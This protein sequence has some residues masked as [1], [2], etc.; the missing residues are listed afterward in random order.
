VK[1]GGNE[2]LTPYQ[3]Q[4]HSERKQRLQRI[5]S[6]AVPDSPITCLSATQCA[7]E[8]PSLAWH[9]PKVLETR[10][11]EQ[12]EVTLPLS[13][14][15]EPA[16]SFTDWLKRQEELN[17]F[18]E[19]FREELTRLVHS[20]LD[21]G[22][23]PRI[24]HVQRVVAHHYGMAVRDLLS[25]RRTREVVLPRQIA[26][27]LAK[28]MTLH[29]LPEIGRRFG[30]KDHTTVLHAIRKLDAKVEKEAAFAAEIETLRAKIMGVIA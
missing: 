5:A 20:H 14:A 21:R 13:P 6:R 2:M 24:D 27:Y 4:L 30:G 26:M 25:R 1:Q 23:C 22:G 17:P 29:S 15:P 12:E 16:F 18:P 9:P 3:E 10:Q 19:D 7:A 28:M 11:A 8:R